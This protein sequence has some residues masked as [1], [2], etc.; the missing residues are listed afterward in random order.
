LANPIVEGTGWWWF[1]LLETTLV[2]LLLLCPPTSGPAE[3]CVSY[4]TEFVQV[5]VRKTQSS[6]V[7]ILFLG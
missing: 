5:N 7:R 6:K 4:Y 1:L 3:E 2:I